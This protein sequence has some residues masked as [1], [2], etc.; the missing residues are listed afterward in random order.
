MW[1]P[2]CYWRFTGLTS[3]D[4][5]Y[6]FI[7]FSCQCY[8]LLELVL[9]LLFGWHRLFTKV[10]K[11]DYL[12]QKDVQEAHVFVGNSSSKSCFEGSPRSWGSC[13]TWWANNKQ[14]TDVN[15]KLSILIGLSHWTDHR[16]TI[17]KSK[18]WRISH[19]CPKCEVHRHVHSTGKLSKFPFSQKTRFEASFF[20]IWF[21]LVFQGSFSISAYLLV[22][23]AL[24]SFLA[25]I[26]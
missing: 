21:G 23:T 5:L 17:L 26:K 1:H 19:P 22:L 11:K 2:L 24:H 12:V 13:W 4:R 7:S 6:Q 20:A 9:K 15:N 16:R 10:R 14:G 3:Q 8:R 25:E 18:S